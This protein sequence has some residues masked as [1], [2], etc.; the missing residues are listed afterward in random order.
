MNVAP[1]AA[2][3]GRRDVTK[4]I[5][6]TQKSGSRLKNDEQKKE[7]LIKNVYFFFSYANL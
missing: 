2:A 3:V 7:G 6:H 5:G 4:F 1:A